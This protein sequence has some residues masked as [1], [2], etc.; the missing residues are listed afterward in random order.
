MKWL[1]ILLMT[2]LLAGAPG[3]GSAQ[4]S[5]EQGAKTPPQPKSSAAAPK[6]AQPAKTYSQEERQAYEKKAAA[7]LEVMQKKLEELRGKQQKVSMQSRRV[8][9]RAMANLQRG[10]LGAKALLTSMK[11]ASKE[12]WGGLKADLDQAMATWER[13][14]A[15]VASRLN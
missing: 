11:Q 4:Q 5:G 15:A 10:L 6:Q 12:T 2:A 1:G 3:I 13:D 14:Y 9:L 7:D 8:V